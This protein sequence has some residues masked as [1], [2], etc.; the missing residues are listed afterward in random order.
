MGGAGMDGVGM[1]LGR[2]KIW[3]EEIYPGIAGGLRGTQHG[4]VAE[5]ILSLREVHQLQIYKSAT[6]NLTSLAPALHSV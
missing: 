2:S 1:E 6:H 5:L 3:W 4:K